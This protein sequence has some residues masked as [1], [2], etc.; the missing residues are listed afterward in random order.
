MERR[1][2]PAVGFHRLGLS[3]GITKI[4]ATTK[5]SANLDRPGQQLRT[6]YSR[7]CCLEGP[8]VI[9]RTDRGT[10]SGAHKM[11]AWLLVHGDWCCI[12][13][14]ANQLSTQT[15]MPTRFPPRGPE[16]DPRG[17][18]PAPTA[19]AGSDIPPGSARVGHEIGLT[20]KVC[21]LA[22]V[23]AETGR[24]GSCTRSCHLWLLDSCC[25]GLDSCCAF[26]SLRATG[27][28]RTPRAGPSAR[29]LHNARPNPAGPNG[30]TAHQESRTQP[31][32]KAR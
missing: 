19:P 10:T 18:S 21:L 13:P 22:D 31:D 23:T 14:R 6:C 20:S 1:L 28:G 24:R 7:P 8:C 25:P 4:S 30:K 2:W 29:P 32:L 26:F 16:A 3:T 17:D 12:G 9:D 5:R 15:P 11:V 27:F